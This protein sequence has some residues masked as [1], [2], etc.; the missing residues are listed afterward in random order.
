MNVRTALSALVALSSSLS[1]TRPLGVIGLVA[2][3]SVAAALVSAPALAQERVL[4]EG[5]VTERALVDALTPPQAASAPE[6]GVR[7]RSFRPAVRPAA[8]AGATAAAGAAAGQ[9]GRASI[10]VTFVTDKA[11]LTTPARSALDVLASAM[12]S[13]RLAGVRFTIEGHAD[14]RGNEDHNMKL[15]QARAE[16]VRGYLISK[17]GLDASRVEAVGKGS[18]NLMN[19]A[20]VAAPENR[21]VTIVS[22]AQ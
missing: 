15:S 17:H 14:P 4:R 11:D 8:T 19:K 7:T 5:Q 21:R 3:G 6:D 1:R 20:N 12:K 9:A 2:V 22:Q 13:D 18:S 10:L 16:S